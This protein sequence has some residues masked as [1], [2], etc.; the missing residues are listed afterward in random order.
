MCVTERIY[1]G[2]C[3]HVVTTHHDC[4]NAGNNCSVKQVD[5]AYDLFCEKCFLLPDPRDSPLH[6]TKDGRR[7]TGPACSEYVYG[8]FRQGI[9][10]RLWAQ[11]RDHMHDHANDMYV[12]THA[13]PDVKWPLPNLARRILGGMHL[14]LMCDFWMRLDTDHP[15]TLPERMLILQLHM[16]CEKNRF[17][18]EG[19][20][21]ETEKQPRELKDVIMGSVELVSLEDTKDEKQCSIC[22]SSFI[23]DSDDESTDFPAKIK[24]CG[25]V[26]GEECIKEWLETNPSCPVCRG[27]ALVYENFELYNDMDE[28]YDRFLQELSDDEDDERLVGDPQDHPQA[29]PQDP[30]TELAH[31]LLNVGE[32]FVDLVHVY[33]NRDAYRN[34][35]SNQLGRFIENNIEHDDPM[36]LD[37][38]PY[39]EQVA[40]QNHS[41][42]VGHP[43]EEAYPEEDE[44]WE[45]YEEEDEDYE[46]DIP[47]MPFFMRVLLDTREK[48]DCDFLFMG[49]TETQMM[50]MFRHRCRPVKREQ[51]GE[52]YPRL[53][54]MDRDSFR[55]IMNSFE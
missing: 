24:R 2:Q 12:F 43:N 20:I 8:E 50:F 15:C 44:E 11:A 23:A 14:I 34:E 16:V 37:P 3:K 1:F 21:D 46:E 45:E 51:P 5:S 26:F 6:E 13:E 40:D 54:E 35:D 25:H 22:F 18:Q 19:T 9:A 47:A 4:D 32:R 33:Q 7:Y 48:R 31:G 39:P 27:E 41:V 38:E 55:C 28:L 49:L 29:P 42:A 10:R 36:D 30:F 52:Q 53:R 17:M